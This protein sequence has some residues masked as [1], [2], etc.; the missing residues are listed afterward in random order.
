VVFSTTAGSI[1]ATSSNLNEYWAIL[2]PANNTG[3]ATVSIV[4][5]DTRL[6]TE[7]TITF[8]RPFTD[9]E[10][11]AGGCPADGNV[12]VRV[13]DDAGNPLSGASV[14][15]GGQPRAGSLET[16]YL[17]GPSTDNW[18]TTDGAG[19]VELRD[20]GTNLDT[21]VTV[22]AGF[23]LREYMTFF[24]MNA[25]DF[26]LPLSLVDPA[27]STGRFTGD[28]TPVPAPNNDPIE[29]AVQL[30]ELTM[31]ALANFS[32]DA[33][34]ADN[35]CYS[36]GGA[37]GDLVVPG[38]IYIPQQCAFSIFI[39]LQ[40]LPEHPY[41][42]G[43]IEYGSERLI[44]L[45]GDAPLSALT[46]G[47][48]V[49]AVAQLDL[50]RI[51]V[52]EVI[53]S[54]PG[55][56][57]QDLDV[58][59]PVV[60][61][62]TCTI[63]NPPANSDVFCVAAGDWDSLGDAGLGPGEGGLFLMGFKLG[64]AAAGTPFDV[65][66]V[67]TVDNAGTFSGIEYV[68]AA[69]ALYIDDMKA[70]IPVGTEGGLSAIMERSGT[71][72]DGG[73]GTMV[74]DD[75]FPIRV[76]TRAVRDYSLSALPGTTEPVPSYVK[77]VIRRVVSETYTA[78]VADDST[79]TFDFDYWTIYTPGTSDTFTLPTLPGTFPR[80]GLPGEQQGLFNPATTAADDVINW[81]SLTI[82]EGY[83]PSFA[84]DAMLLSDFRRYISHVTTNDQD[85]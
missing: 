12:R 64:D 3:T 35:Q 11:G 52:N 66:S 30:P 72:F 32:L 79:R 16:T 7:P 6:N 25:S 47:D 70:G 46:G 65:T 68:A 37:A 20:F 84:Y 73:G 74:F 48:I 83:S 61:N 2:R 69:I 13:V 53:V 14:L 26:V 58:T 39:C 62:V 60:G 77:T 15:I 28:I 19:Y 23:D 55:P 57:T 45:R 56:T 59:D 5:D 82:T 22:T 4:A 54:A 44:S 49:A 78:C 51:G 17:A 34:L 29:I 27:P 10:G 43:P 75:F 31:E 76:M 41:T 9:L 71:A 24:D 67:E 8:A 21:M 50:N 33:I 81:Q 42:S 36:A 80:A 63:D 1:S 38:N 40:N 85:F 18:A